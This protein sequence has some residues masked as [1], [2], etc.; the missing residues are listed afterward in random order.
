M[1]IVLN[2]SKN[3]S[4]NSRLAMQSAFL[5]RIFHP[6]VWIAIEFDREWLRVHGPLSP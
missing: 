6:P 3:G 5:T 4:P 2:G 1:A